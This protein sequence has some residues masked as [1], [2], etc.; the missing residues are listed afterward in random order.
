MPNRSEPVSEGTGPVF[1]AGDGRTGGTST[2]LRYRRWFFRIGFRT[3]TRTRTRTR[4]SARTHSASEHRRR[5]E[6]FDDIVEVS[7]PNDDS[8]NDCAEWLEYFRI[9]GRVRKLVRK[10]GDFVRVLECKC[11]QRVAY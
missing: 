1:I 11:D 6:Y 2:G 4:T 8:R 7:G 5:L 9:L 3:H 10:S